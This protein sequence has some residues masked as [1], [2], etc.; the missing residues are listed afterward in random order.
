V[1]D[2]DPQ[3]RLDLPGSERA[4]GAARTALTAMNGSLHILSEAQ[5]RDARLLASE[6][7]AN[8]L[9]HG[10]A[11]GTITLSMHDMPKAIRVE[12]SDDGDGFDPDELQ[13]PSSDRARGWGLALVGALADRWGVE[14]D[15]ATTVWFEIDHPRREAPLGPRQIG[16]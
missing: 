7:V 8:A 12:V 13:E 15:I 14:R 6:L 11:D 1:A 10:A 3:L 4:P 5:L 9:H 16:R 2:D